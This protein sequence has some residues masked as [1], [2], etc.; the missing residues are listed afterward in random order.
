M[1]ARD[2]EARREMEDLRDAFA[3]ELP[4][5]VAA[6]GAQCHAF[7]RGDLDVTRTSALVR[8]VHSLAGS[9]TTFGRPDVSRAA[10]RVEDVLKALTAG[11]GR[12]DDLPGALR[13]L[14]AAA[15]SS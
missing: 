10:R 1:T 6:I 7:L 4:T 8:D 11:T 9:G 14:E 5:R 15:R 12:A 3:A 2:D 13:S